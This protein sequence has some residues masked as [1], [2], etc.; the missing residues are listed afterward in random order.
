MKST[1]F[2][3]RIANLFIAHEN[4][5]ASGNKQYEVIHENHLE[6]MV[7]ENL[8]RGSGFNN[9][10]KFNWEESSRNKLVFDTA[11]HH[12][13]ENGYYC[14]WSEHKVIVTPDLLFGFNIRVTGKNVRDI[15]DYIAEMFSNFEWREVGN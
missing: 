13:D 12:M 2:Y 10:T 1:E 9:G 3:S 7:K 4:C 5:V 6:E 8:P 14:G 15:K 11:F